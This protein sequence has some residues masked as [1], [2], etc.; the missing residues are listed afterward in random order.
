MGRSLRV[1]AV[2]ALLMAVSACSTQKD[3]GF[4]HLATPKP[5]SSGAAGNGVQLVAGN[6]FQPGTLQIK[7]GQS[8][9]WTYSDSS[10]QPHNVLS[11]TK[12]FDSNPQCS[13]TDQTKCMSQG[14]TFSFTFSKPGTYHYYCIIHG[15]PGGVG[16]SGVIEV[17]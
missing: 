1:L 7:A 16:M 4:N 6:A 10:G 11:D 3:T 15:G 12:L 9:T 8:V 5:S 2:V 14:S 13:G 17:S